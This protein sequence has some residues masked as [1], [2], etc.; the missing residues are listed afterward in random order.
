MK[1]LKYL[2]KPLE[3]MVVLCLLAAL[4]YFRSI[5]FHSN[6]NQY[7]DMGLASAEEQFEIKIPSHINSDVELKTVV[8]SECESVDVVKSE[9]NFDRKIVTI[10]DKEQDVADELPLPDK[11]VKS[12]DEKILIETISDAVST[13]SE[14]MDSLFNSNKPEPA[15]EPVLK[16]GNTEVILP[17]AE[18]NNADS[19]YAKDTVVQ[20]AV[21]ESPSVDTKQVLYTARKLFWSGNVQGSE[22]LYMELVNLDKGDPDTYGE[23]GNV[24]YTQGKWKQAG[25]AYYE[26]AIRLLEQNKS[27]QAI[28][29]VSY[30]LRVIQG[31]DMESAD[32]LK[33]KISG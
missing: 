23:L 30:L 10:N 7:I 3:L 19:T 5:I 4:V 13:I 32:K 11:V 26:A 15:A 27:D 29:R 31:L 16:D 12:G 17:L 25:Q 9:E 1:I 18:K 24:Y 6:V 22:R 21:A 20:L 33:N 28:D 14:K 8:Q 2:I